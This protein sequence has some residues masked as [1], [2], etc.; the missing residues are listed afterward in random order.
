VVAAGK[1]APG[2]VVRRTGGATPRRSGTIASDFGSSGVE[3]RGKAKEKEARNRLLPACIR[4]TVRRR[5]G[6]LGG[7]G[8]PIGS[9]LDIRM[10]LFLTNQIEV[11]FAAEEE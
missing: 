7:A 4:L 2:T 10:H 3:G 1:V 5:S 6:S 9:S 11:R 8:Q